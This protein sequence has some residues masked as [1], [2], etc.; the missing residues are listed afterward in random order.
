MNPIQINK[1]LDKAFDYTAE[2]MKEMFDTYG[3]HDQPYFLH[4]MLLQSAYGLRCYGFELS[5]IQELISEE[6]ESK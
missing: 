3:E 6:M 4:I 2:I 1:T 5:D